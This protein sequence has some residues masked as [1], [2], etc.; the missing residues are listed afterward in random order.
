MLLSGYGLHECPLEGEPSTLVAD[1]W[2]A[3]PTNWHANNGAVATRDG[4]LCAVYHTCSTRGARLMLYEENRPVRMLVSKTKAPL[5]PAW[6]LM[7]V[8]C[9]LWTTTASA[10]GIFL[11]PA[12]L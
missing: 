2:C 7:T 9:A 1:E 11:R 10:F 12:E 6:P 4:R 8:L 5:R 3:D